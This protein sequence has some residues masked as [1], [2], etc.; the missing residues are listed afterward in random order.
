MVSVDFMNLDE[1]MK[2][3]QK[4]DTV[5]SM[6]TPFEAGLEA[7]VK[8]GKTMANAAEKAGVRSIMEL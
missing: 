4:V 6:T 8:Q 1:L 5:F 7:E 3:M 2:I